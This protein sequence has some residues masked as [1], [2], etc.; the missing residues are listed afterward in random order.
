[1]SNR[2]PDWRNGP[3]DDARRKHDNNYNY[4]GSSNPKST[5][6]K[7]TKNPN[8]KRYKREEEPVH[9]R[10]M[11]DSDKERARRHKD[12]KREMDYLYK[13]AMAK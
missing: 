12:L 8:L 4:H 3:A 6:S 13:K 5:S 2:N 10:A 7:K 9:F 1:V 11:N